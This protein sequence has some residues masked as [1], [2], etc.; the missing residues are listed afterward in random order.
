MAEKNIYRVIERIEYPNCVVEISKRGT[1]TAEEAE[2]YQRI[3]KQDA[4]ESKNAYADL[5]EVSSVLGYDKRGK[6]DRVRKHI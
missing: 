3:K 1:L 6:S 2:S 4:E 5:A